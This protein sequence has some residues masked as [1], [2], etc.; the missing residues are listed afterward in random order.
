MQVFSCLTILHSVPKLAS[1]P[2]LVCSLW[3]STKY[4][5]LHYLNITYGHSYY[6]VRVLSCV[7]IVTSLWRQS[8]FT[9]RYIWCIVIDKGI[10]QQCTRFKLRACV[11]AKGGHFKLKL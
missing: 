6:D 2:Y 11:E 3:I 5:T 9:L 7:L 10:K 8:L 1:T 4:R